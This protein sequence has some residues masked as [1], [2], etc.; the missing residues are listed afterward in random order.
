MACGHRGGVRCTSVR[1]GD[2]PGPVRF[3]LQGVR[4]ALL[5]GAARSL[6]P[7]SQAP[8]LTPRGW[9]PRARQEC[10]PQPH[11][12]ES[13]C[14]PGALHLLP[15]VL[16]AP[17]SSRHY[18]MLLSR[19]GELWERSRQVHSVLSGQSLGFCSPFLHTLSQGRAR[20]F[21]ETEG[22]AD[23]RDKQCSVGRLLDAPRPGSDPQPPGVRAGAPTN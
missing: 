13:V 1:P 6:A 5:G 7:R 23:V 14:A 3:R 4:R 10:W 12:L 15:R 18:S 19:S 9:R 8:S 20:S 11:S 16:A 22:D 21:Q 17:R 2:G